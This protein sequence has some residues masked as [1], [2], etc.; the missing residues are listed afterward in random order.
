LWKKRFDN[1]LEDLETFQVDS[2]GTLKDIGS[3][4]T[5]YD[6]IGGQYMGIVKF[7]PNGWNLFMQS[8]KNTTKSLE[9]VDMTSMLNA[10][11]RSGIE[12]QCVRCSDL[13]LECDNLND[14]KVYERE[15]Q[16]ELNK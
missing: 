13:W 14:V 3:K 1:P 2:N 4:P 10:T 12:I 15:Y 16:F 7:T 6:Q 11:L 9:K 5:S 8:L